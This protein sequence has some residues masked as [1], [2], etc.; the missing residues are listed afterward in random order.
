MSLA[1]PDDRQRLL[2]MLRTLSY[3]KRSI[4]LSS[5]KTSDFYIDCK[6]TVLTPEGHYRV[7][8]LLLDAIAR[9]TPQAAAVGGM[10]L[11]ADPLASAVSLT[12]WIANK[13][14]PAFIVRKERKGHGTGAWIEGRSNLK[15]R[16]PVAIVEDVVTTGASTLRAVERVVEE[17]LVVAGA[18]CL[19]DRDEG[20]RQAL[21]D[22][23]IALHAL[24][25]R[26]DFTG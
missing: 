7:G 12:S 13:P 18:F 14:L 11:G 15:D 6:R 3:E 4:V 8:R 24:F 23:G 21:K 1:T 26:R 10:T 17:G 16:D 22:E 9:E 2:E 5:G 19:V 20:G 25:V